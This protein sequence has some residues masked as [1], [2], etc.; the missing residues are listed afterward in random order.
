MARKNGKRAD[1]EGTL[2]KR[3]DKNGKVIG[4]KGAV[5]V[6]YDLN[7]YPDR[8]WVSGTSEGEVREKMEALKTGRNAGLLAKAEGVTVSEY[9]DRW[10]KH[11]VHTVR[12]I[13]VQSY[14]NTFDTYLLPSLGKVKLE[15]LSAADLD[16]LYVSL[17]EKGLSARVVRYTHTVTHAM[18]KQ[19]MK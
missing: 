10:L 16:H 13:T 3:K 12:P 18:L 8:R 6:G 7:G 17:L 15:K 4:W 19:A 9:A 5:T 2:V 1:G 14:R 11:K